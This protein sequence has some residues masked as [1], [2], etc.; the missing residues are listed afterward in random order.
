MRSDGRPSRRGRATGI[1]GPAR[2]YDAAKRT[3]GCKRH[4]FVDATGLT[5]LAHVHSAD[6]HDRLGAQALIG[7][8]SPG[9]FRHLELAWADGA[10][11]GTFARWLEAERG[12]RVE[13]PKHRDRHLWRYGLEAK[14][15]GFQVTLRRWVVER[16]FAWLSRSRRLAR[17]YEC[18]LT[19]GEAMIH[20]AM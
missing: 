1:G 10:Y 7:Q 13:A 4:I 3:A 19:T 8:A 18:L 2:G 12:L 9:G 11:A 5:L 14:L 6:L 20:A 16:T 15:K 17:D